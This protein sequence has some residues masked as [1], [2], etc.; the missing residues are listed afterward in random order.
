MILIT[1]AVMVAPASAYISGQNVEAKAENMVDIAENALKA[2]MDCVETTEANS[3]I[4]ELIIVADLDEYF[5]GN[6]S[7]CVENETLVNGTAVTV[8]GAGWAALNASKEA[9]LVAENA[10]DYEAVIDQ[11]Q[12]A[13]EIFR[14]SLKAI[15]GILIDVGVETCP[16]CDPLEIEEAIERAQARIDTLQDLLADEEL[17]AILEQAQANLTEATNAL[18]DVEVAREYLQTANQ[19]ISDVCQDLKT[20]A[21]DLNPGRIRSYIARVFK[22]NER[23]QEKFRNKLGNQ[24]SINQFLQGLGYD[25]EEE[26][27][28]HFD[29]LIENAENAKTVKE[30]TK[31]LQDMGKIMK[32][33]E[34]SLDQLGN[35]G[36]NQNSG[37]GKSNGNG[38]M[39]NGNSP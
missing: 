18:P 14:D 38:N 8:D 5:Y 3:T 2:V 13:L 20:I 30:A 11:A 15:N 7:L 33:T 34:D 17:L 25:N 28:E 31:A 6:I 4:I 12:E 23:V 16:T 24:T 19:L 1:V 29:N 9:L 26:F 37:N 22:N 27:W 32:N 21:Q 39:G 36:N 10:T 35:Q